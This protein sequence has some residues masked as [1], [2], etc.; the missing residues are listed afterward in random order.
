MIPALTLTPSI[1]TKVCSGATSIF[2]HAQKLKWKGIV[3]A[4][5]ENY[6]KIPIFVITL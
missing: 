6:L 5:E 3:Y 1:P 2:Q 4:Y